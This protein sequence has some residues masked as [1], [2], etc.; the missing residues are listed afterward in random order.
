MHEEGTSGKVI[1]FL[2]LGVF[3]AIF[4]LIVLVLGPMLGLRFGA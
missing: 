4:M 3:P 1:L 2:V